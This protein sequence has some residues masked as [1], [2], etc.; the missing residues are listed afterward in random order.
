MWSDNDT[1]R[2][3][4]NF[5]TVA[6]TAA[7]IIFRANGKPL[8]MGVSGGWGAGKSSMVKLIRESLYERFGE[9]FVFVEFNAWLYQ[10]YDDAKAALM[11]VIAQNLL[12]YQKK[13]ERPLD[14][15]L[16]FL[17]RVKW[18][19]A[20]GW[21]IGIAA[22]IKT[23]GLGAAAFFSGMKA[24]SHGE[25]TA[26]DIDSIKGTGKKVAEVGKSL[27]E[28]KREESPPKEIHDL[29]EHFAKLLADMDVTL[30]VFVDDL[31][32]CLPDTAIS[33]LEA[34]RLFLFMDRTA[35]VIAAD[36]KMIRQAVRAHFKEAA[37][38]DDLVTNYFDKL[39]Q[40]PIRVPPLGT[41][42]VR[43]YL[44]LLFIDN[45][46]QSQTVKDTARKAICTQLG[47]TWQGKRIDREFVVSLIPQCPAN[48][49]SQFDLADR[50]S[51]LMT[52]AQQIRGNPRLIKR[53]LNTLYIRLAAATAQQVTVDEAALSKTLLFERCGNE[54]AHLQLLQAI[55]DDDEGKPRFLKPWEEAA[56]KG[57]EISLP[58]EWGGPF[59][60][61]WLS[62]PPMLHDLDLRAVVYVSREHMPII[63]RA[64]Q[65]STEAGKLL[66]ALL[67]LKQSATGELVTRLKSLGKRELSLLME[68]LLVRAKQ[69]QEWGAVPI[70]HA[71][72]AVVAADESLG[73]TLGRFL[74]QVPPGQ[75]KTP[76]I[77]LL[78]D[79]PWA[80]DLFT[81][82]LNAP[83]VA[84][85][86][87]KAITAEQKEIK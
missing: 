80:R 52:S 56:T 68:R 58:P 46:D 21:A 33:T 10:G 15:A 24:A 73:D 41:Q 67:A 53:F 13:H 83:A 25:A 72:L 22:A 48:L 85:P 20:A 69:I 28:P 81:S 43:A 11:E 1:N 57:E 76:L 45:S 42:E 75:I 71:C 59:I 14:G 16:D 18:V 38:D 6:D 87:K 17:G 63:T 47:E 36:E 29:R 54:A 12:E 9:K 37:L 78:K 82:W 49:M 5:R 8:S 23:G 55:S 35:F 27:V 7:E 51:P 50:I 62:L 61:D 66:E 64:D 74:A 32:R 39:I 84:G 4:L 31:D 44:F 40:I 65:L 60:K 19:R 26:A 34:M 30:V 86:V 2:D 3:F 79:K 77:P 70:L